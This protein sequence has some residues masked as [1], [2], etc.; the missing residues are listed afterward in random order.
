MP[1]TQQTTQPGPMRL[2]KLPL[3]AG[4]GRGEGENKRQLKPL[5]TAGDALASRTHQSHA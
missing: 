4:E 3:Q 1:P 2:A 5:V